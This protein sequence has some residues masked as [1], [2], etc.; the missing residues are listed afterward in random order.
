M[1]YVS[2]FIELLRSRPA[3]AV[4]LAALMQAAL[5]ILVPALFY[6]SPPGDLAAVI[7][8]GHEFPPHT[9]PPALDGV[10]RWTAVNGF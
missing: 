3:L 4:W 8:L 5:W 9:E 6:G 1:L 7:A 10:T 2:I